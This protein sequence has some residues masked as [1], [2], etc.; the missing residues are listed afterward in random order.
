MENSLKIVTYSLIFI[1]LFSSCSKEELENE[2]E[3]N[4]SNLVGKWQQI[5]ACTNSSGEANY[6]DF[7]YTYGI[8]GQIDCDNACAGGGVYTNFSYTATENSVSVKPNSVSD[9]C[10]VTPTLASPYTVSYSISGDILTLDGEKFRKTGSGSNTGSN[11]G[12]I[13][14][15]TKKDN[16]C[17]NITIT[18]DG[19]STK[20]LSQFHPSGI[21]DC[22]QGAI[23]NL[24]KGSHG[25][26]A[27]CGSF[28]WNGTFSIS[29]NG[30]LIYELH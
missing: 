11:N 18:V 15:Y 3:S 6:F 24:S 10:G 2:E 9:Y 30:C 5:N 27:K 1:S 13:A 14:F 26:V 4:S 28:I 25:F 21:N 7:N 8:V 22:S 23:F 29:A 17:G 12:N 16:G 20:N 19:N